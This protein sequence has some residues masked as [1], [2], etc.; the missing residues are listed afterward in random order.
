MK[1]INGEDSSMSEIE[2]GTKTEDGDEEVES[3]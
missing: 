2:G 1:A 3:E